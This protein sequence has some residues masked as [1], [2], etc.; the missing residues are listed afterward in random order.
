MCKTLLIATLLAVAS[1]HAAKAATPVPPM[2]VKRTEV[3]TVTFDEMLKKIGEEIVFC[4]RLHGVMTKIA[5]A[6][7]QGNTLDIKGEENSRS[8]DKYPLKVLPT[9]EQLKSLK[10]KPICDP[11]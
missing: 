4:R 8:I 6:T 5:S 9:P 1:F 11:N 2:P 10:G 7:M 3:A